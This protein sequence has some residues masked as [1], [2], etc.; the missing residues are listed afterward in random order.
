MNRPTVSDTHRYSRLPFDALFIILAFGLAYWI[1]YDLQW[2]RMVEPAFQVPFSVYIPSI[3]SLAIIL[4]LVYWSEGVY[5]HRRGAGFFEEFYLIFRG[6]V[7]GIATMIVIVFLTMPNFYSRLIFIYTGIII[8]IL[9]GASRAIEV[10][11][12]SSRYRR[13]IGVERVLIVGAGE[14]ARSVMRTAV[15]RPDFGYR[16]VGFVDDDPIKAQTDIGRYPALGTTER[17][18]DLLQGDG[19]DVVISTLPWHSHEK[20][21]QIM[22]ACDSHDVQVR[23]VPDLYQIALGNVVVENLN[24]IPLLGFRA[25]VLRDWQ[26]AYKRAADILISSV[27]LIVLSP[28]LL[29]VELAIRIDSPGPVIFRQTRVGKGGKQF[30]C[31]KFRSMYVDAEA[32]MAELQ[33]RNEATGPIFKMRNDPRRT[34][35]GGLLRRASI[36][37]LPQ[38][39]NVLKGEMSIIGPRPPLPSEVAKY[40][41]WHLRRLDIAPGITGLWQVSGRSNLTFDE[42]VLLDIFYIEN[43]SPFLDLRILLRSVP[44][45]LFGSGAY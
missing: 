35:V 21:L 27:S 6:T 23:I 34:R 11:V 9:I 40:A 42:M 5:R 25:P 13:G 14:V 4:L 32:R 29:L 10:A 18:D 26:V 33:Q 44:A 39:W 8:L 38:L 19:I 22:N 37:E 2:I 43:W 31:L 45:V 12:V 3:A 30:T 15:A 24:G 20:I 16:I 1:R 41:P 7:V 36:D 17:L 28:L